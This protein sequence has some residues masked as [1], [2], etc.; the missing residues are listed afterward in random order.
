L[1]GVVNVELDI[2]DVGD[3]GALPEPPVP[4]AYEMV[5]VVDGA[6]G[7]S[8]K[9]LRLKFDRVS[10]MEAKVQSVCVLPDCPKPISA[11]PES[12]RFHAKTVLFSLAVAE[13]RCNWNEPYLLPV[14]QSMI[15]V[16]E[17]S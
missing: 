9:T 2:T 5:N 17:S 12:W 4:A 10:L 3:P 6:T 8:M 7:T 1:A 11:G 13:R 16:S 14:A 15:G